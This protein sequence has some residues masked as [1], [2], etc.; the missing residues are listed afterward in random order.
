MYETELCL[1]VGMDNSMAHLLVSDILTV[2]ARPIPYKLEE[3]CHGLTTCA[4]KGAAVGSAGRSGNQSLKNQSQEDHAWRRLGTVIL[5]QAHQ[6]H[7]VVQ[8]SQ[9]KGSHEGAV[10]QRNHHVYMLA[11]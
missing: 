9:H 5:H 4:A 3:V 10:I 6:D 11:S 2:N 1:K 7:N 8:V